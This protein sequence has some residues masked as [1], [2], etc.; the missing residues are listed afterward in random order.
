MVAHQ[1]G[2][3]AALVAIQPVQLAELQRIDGA[4]LG[5]IPP[6]SLGD[7]VEQGGDAEQLGLAQ[8]GEHLVAE[9]V[10]LA[11]GRVGEAMDVLE[12]AMGVLIHRV[13]VEHV[14]LHLADDEVPLGQIGREDPVLVHQGE[15]LADAVGVA[16]QR[17]EQATALR[18]VL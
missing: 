9:R 6:P 3:Q 17:H 13:G 7:V 5:V 1:P 11:A 2:H 8:L 10:G 16:Q 15:G 18:Q 4:E 14:E 12:Q